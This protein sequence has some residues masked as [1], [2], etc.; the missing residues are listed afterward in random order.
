MENVI[1]ERKDGVV[2]FTLNRP[3]RRNAI[4]VSTWKLLSRELT[5]VAERDADRVL[6]L[7][8]SQG[9][10]CA[11][12]DL[13]ESGSGEVPR[14]SSPVDVM[15]DTVNRF[16]LA[17]HQLAKPCIAAVEGTAAGAGANLAWGC[18]LVVAGRSARFGQVFVRR[19]LSL[20]SGGSWILPRLVGLQK[21]KELAF[22]GD[23][24]GAQ[25]AQRLGAVSE[26]VEDGSALA[27]AQARA[28]RL[29]AA[30][31]SA[32]AFIKQGLDESLEKSFEACLEAEALAVQHCAQTPEFAEQVRALFAKS[33]R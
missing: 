25:E 5:Q 23:W 32:L 22:F 28:T 21:A 19:G 2:T 29:V 3:E 24:L 30:S 26:V 27:S 13:S 18:D 9:N 31:P 1:V 33:R 6:V 10:F 14:D 7:T 8:G 15:R 16:C 20:D 11:G 12:G 4:D 17:L